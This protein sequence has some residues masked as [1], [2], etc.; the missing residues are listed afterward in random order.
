MLSTASAEEL[1]K[2]MKRHEKLNREN[3]SLSLGV[4]HQYNINRSAPA[5]TQNPTM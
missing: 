1:L 3:K 5:S 2:E 4:E